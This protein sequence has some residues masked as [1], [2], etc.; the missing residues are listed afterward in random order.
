MF[1]SKPVALCKYRMIDDPSNEY[2]YAEEYYSN[3][4]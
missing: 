2:R 4:Q 3:L 1:F